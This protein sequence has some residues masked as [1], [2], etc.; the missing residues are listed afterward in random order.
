MKQ[1]SK[2]KK[3]ICAILL[4]S[5]IIIIGIVMVVLF[6]FNKQ[7]KY[8]QTQSVEI[9][10]EQTFDYNK[11]KEIANE[12]LGRNN[13]VQTI[14]IYEDMVV[15][16]A[17]SISEEQKNQIVEKIKENY[18]FEQ[19]AEETTINTIAK[20]RIIDMYKKYI[21][22]FIISGIIVLIYMVIRYNKKGII[23]TLINTILIPIIAELLCLSI[24]AI[25]RIPLGIYTPIII[26]IVYIISILY[27]T[28]KYEK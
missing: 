8:K 11:I 17:E 18:E 24:I 26:I 12:V 6:G 28:N 27:L 16:R 20:T 21:K 2:K 23:K 22:P 13:I 5:I 4:I 19:T 9:Y 1:I 7:L 25:T 14:E 15:I 3:T 10:I